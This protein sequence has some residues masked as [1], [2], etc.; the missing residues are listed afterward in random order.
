MSEEQVPPNWEDTYTL[1]YR[2][3]V[4]SRSFEEWKKRCNSLQELEF[5][6][7]DVDPS[8]GVIY[9]LGTEDVDRQSSRLHNRFEVG[10]QSQRGYHTVDSGK[11]TL[12]PYWGV[13][14]ADRVEGR[15]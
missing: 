14:I 9:A 8:G 3:A 11:Y 15:H 1:E 2:Q 6:T 5:S 10:M 12:T 7:G 4:F 13:A